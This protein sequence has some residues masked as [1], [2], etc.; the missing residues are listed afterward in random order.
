MLLKDN[1]NKIN[2]ISS[3]IESNSTLAV[4]GNGLDEGASVLA[5]MI[6]GSNGLGARHNIYFNCKVVGDNNN[7]I[8][9]LNY[10][11]HNDREYVNLIFAIPSTIKNALGEEFYMGTLPKDGVFK[12]YKYDDDYGNFIINMFIKKAG[13]IPREFI[14][15]AVIGNVTTNGVD[16][17]FV[18]NPC[19]YGLLDEEDKRRFGDKFLKTAFR[20]TIDFEHFYKINDYE[21]FYKINDV[22]I[23]EIDNIL[24]LYK[25]FGFSDLFFEQLRDY[26]NN[27]KALK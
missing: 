4:H 27:A 8:D 17:R 21:R 26:V 10:V 11:H 9:A 23:D 20:Y 6:L 1:E 25:R 3:L 2:E 5:S 15:G 7:L 19:Y 22:T 14:V 24:K 18:V 16:E 12:A 13:Y